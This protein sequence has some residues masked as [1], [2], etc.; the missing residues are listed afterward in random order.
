MK[1][2]GNI[3]VVGENSGNFGLPRGGE[4]QGDASC[5]ESSHPPEQTFVVN[6]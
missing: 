1:G 2:L 4:A 3:F 6:I 5:A